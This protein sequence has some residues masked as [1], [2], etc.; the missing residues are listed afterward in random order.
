MIFVPSGTTEKG[1]R[2]LA[3]FL[4]LYGLLKISV[5]KN[6]KEGGRNVGRFGFFYSLI[7][8][9][10]I[11]LEMEYEFKTLIFVYEV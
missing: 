3:P 6:F 5:L 10:V 9:T 11:W 7:L 1:V 2:K 4:V 8:L